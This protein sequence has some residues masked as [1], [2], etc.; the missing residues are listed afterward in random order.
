MT[1]SRKRFCTGLAAGSVLVWL[2]GCGGGGGSAG[3]SPLGGGP[4]GTGSGGAGDIPPALDSCGATGTQ[5]TGNH[6][7]VL[8]IP[9][10][11]LDSTTPKTYSIG[12]TAGHDHTVTFSVAQLAQ[13]K[14]K[15][16]VTV[17][18]SVTDA[19]DHQVTTQ[20]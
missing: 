13:L 8:I 15:Q 19:H 10:A 1:V 14:A 18:S 11:D 7:H 9:P 17:V 5:I 2:Q 4:S 16:A 12:S 3:T 6:G 20:C